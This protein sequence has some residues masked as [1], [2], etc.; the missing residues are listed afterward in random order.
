MKKY[1]ILILIMF[2]ILNKKV[3]GQW[4]YTDNNVNV[5]YTYEINSNNGDT[6]L[7]TSLSV[8]D[9]VIPKTYVLGNFVFKM[10]NIRNK[11]SISNILSTQYQILKQQYSLSELINISS[12]V[13]KLLIQQV[14]SLQRDKL[15][16]LVYQALGIYNSL[17]K[18]SLRDNGGSEVI[19][20]PSDS[21]IV[22]INTFS[23]EEEQ[24]INIKKFISYLTTQK[25]INPN[26]PGYDY[27]LN[28]LKNETRPTLNIKEL[29]AKLA[30]YFNSTMGRWP[31][32][33]QCG[34]CGNYTGNCYYWNSICLMHDYQCQTCSPAW[35]CGPTCVSSSCSGNTISW[36]WFLV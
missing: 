30:D 35:Y 28:A 13:E 23:C 32:G 4:V 36:Y 19:F 16:S 12:S 31:Q 34:C 14:N 1:S 8:S 15:R 2:L 27:F 20:T 9:L 24:V 11:D 3:N 10:N 21:Y 22:G 33:G 7:N 18:G 17:I 6:I 5:T 25:S 29:N 26:D